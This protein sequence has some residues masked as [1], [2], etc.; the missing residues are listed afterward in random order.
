MKVLICAL[1]SL[2][3]CPYVNFYIDICRNNKIDFCVLYP[4]RG[5]LKEHFDYSTIRFDW[6]HKGNNIIQLLKYRKFASKIIN[7]DK[8]DYII[9]LTT[10]AAVLHAKELLKKKR[11]FLVDVRD[12][13]REYNYFYYTIEKKIILQADDVV[14]SSPRFREFLPDRNYIDAFNVPKEIKDEKIKFNLERPIRIAYVGTIAY[15]EQCELL[16]RLVEKDERFRFELYGN[17][18]NGDRIKNFI[19]D[20]HIKNSKYF[21]TYKPEKKEEIIINSD[22]L[23]NAY[24]NN[25]PLLRYALSNKLTDAA[26]YKKVVLNSPDT[27]MDELLGECSYAIDLLKEEN[28]D[29]LYE[30]YENINPL[31]V[32]KYLNKLLMKIISTNS[33]ASKR[34]KSSFENN[35]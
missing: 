9:I 1:N 3:Y 31:E 6:N 24:G 25:K 4:D 14:L 19:S 17:D 27:C 26:M 28:L 34:I 7:S 30:W 22:I 18:I 21:G 12:Y 32:E 2:R 15:P 23:F 5:M 35:N 20:N 13:T 8:Y 33:E 11:H 29:G 16:M 10:G